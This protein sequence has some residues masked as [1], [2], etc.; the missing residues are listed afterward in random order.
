MLFSAS[1]YSAEVRFSRTRHAE[2]VA[3]D[4]SFSADD[5][6]VAGTPQQVARRFRS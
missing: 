4:A 1:V 5:L 3:L 6:T 2:V